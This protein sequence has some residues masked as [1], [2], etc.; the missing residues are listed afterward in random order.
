MKYLLDTNIISEIQKSAC[1]H[2]VKSFTDRIPRED[3]FLSVITM[4]ELCY[5]IEKLPPGKRKHDLEL[6]FYANVPDYFKDRILPLDTEIMLEWGRLCAGTGRSLSTFDSLIA[7]TAL[8]YHLTLVT[9]NTKDF[10]NIAGISLL[11][12]WE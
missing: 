11:N 8:C 4:G 3:M 10:K 5:G 2:G 6:W 1:N 7:S 12:P 9:R